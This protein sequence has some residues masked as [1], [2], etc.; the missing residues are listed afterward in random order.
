MLEVEALERFIWCTEAAPFE[1]VDKSELVFTRDIGED[2]G[3]VLFT[4][5]PKHL[6][7]LTPQERRVFPLYFRETI[8][9]VSAYVPRLHRRMY[10]LAGYPLLFRTFAELPE[11]PEGCLSFAS[12]Y[13]YLGDEAS[14]L[15]ILA[16]RPEHG[17]TGA[18]MAESVR[19]WLSAVSDFKTIVALW[20]ATRALDVEALA[21]IVMWSECGL[22]LRK[23]Y[24]SLG[25]NGRLFPELSRQDMDAHGV[26]AGDLVGGA[27]L[28]L[29]RLLANLVQESLLFSAV[30]F[31]V[32]G[33]P[34]RLVLSPVDLLSAMCLQ[35]AAAI[36]ENKDFRQCLQC[37]KWFEASP[38]T[39]QANKQFCG[40]SCRMKAYRERQKEAVRLH[41]QGETVEALAERF[42]SDTETVRSW[43]EKAGRKSARKQSRGGSR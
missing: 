40:A 43:I 33:R 22:W 5:V 37:E 12:R 20:D 1:L 2:S 26:E 27:R 39:L 6:L 25:E 10:R 31:P 15:S 23:T 32:N 38:A 41:A 13:G 24:D 34:S 7:S 29:Q 35:M 30:V 16:Y 19:G 36:L 8:D 21:G 42:E 28:L 4:D 14:E 17:R 3:L 9:P 18:S 11:T